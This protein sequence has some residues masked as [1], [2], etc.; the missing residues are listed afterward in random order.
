MLVTERLVAFLSSLFGGLGA[1]LTCLG[2]YGVMSYVTACR[3]HEIG[4]RIALGAGHTETLRLVARETLWLV[5]AGVLIGAPAAWLTMRA[6]ESLL[7]EVGAADL[8]TM[9]VSVGVMMLVALVAT[10]VPARRALAVD[11]VTA[12]RF[13]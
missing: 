10:W 4:I 5:I 2:L 11:P 9:T 13:E 6:S 8:P 3:T 7:F 12:L 1:V